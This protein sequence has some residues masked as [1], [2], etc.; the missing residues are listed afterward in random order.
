LGIDIRASKRACPTD[1][2]DNDRFVIGYHAQ[3]FVDVST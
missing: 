2:D 3:Y 1:S